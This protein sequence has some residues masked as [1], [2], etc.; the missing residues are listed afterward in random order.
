MHRLSL[1]SALFLA[2][3]AVGPN[4]VAPEGSPQSGFRSKA[5]GT[6]AA[7][8][9]EAA[10]QAWW[11]RFG[12]PKLNELIAQTIAGNQDVKAAIANIKAARAE[13]N[14]ASFD[15]LP[16]V[17]A[18]GDYTNSRSSGF[19]LPAA[20]P[21]DVETYSTG[22]D[23]TW[24]LDLFGRVRRNVEAA[25]A[26]LGAAEAGRDDLLVSITAETARTY[27]ELRGLQN[28]LSVARRNAENQR[29]TVDLTNKLLEGGRGTDLDTSR[30]KAQLSTTL[31]TIPPL[32]GAVDKAFHRLGVLSGQP[33]DALR[34]R[35]TLAPLPSR[36]P[37]IRLGDPAALLRRRPD[38]RA[39]ERQLAAA[40][41]RIGVATADL[42]PR[43]TANGSAGLTA[44][45]FTG[46]GQ[47]G[48]DNFSFGPSI[49]WA[50]L[51]S[52]RRLQLVKAAGARTEARLA[53][54]QQTVLLA[55]EDVENSITDYGREQNRRNHLAD[56]VQSSAK[57]ASLARQR[58]DQGAAGFLEVLDAERVKLQ[59]EVSLAES[60][61]RTATNL[62]AVFK[63]LGG[64]WDPT[65]RTK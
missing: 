2:S 55:L 26:D 37:S 58:F 9:N 36:L 20:F 59:A 4:Y 19:N 52:P 46:L 22:F 32:E 25:S 45:S 10:L 63:A 1:L 43:I 5:S 8:P 62:I 13:R 17:T 49:S 33:P 27:L 65:A 31:A 38:I 30:A 24:E 28:Q 39:A 6:L 51:D 35:L 15:F 11:Q 7:A 44:G 40:T 3:C 23:A 61:T 50:F 54:Y 57:A 60:Q 42:F 12:D 14:F 18:G 41:A 16:V 56:A 29:A 34:G 47:N 21:R 64:G 53:T 48:A